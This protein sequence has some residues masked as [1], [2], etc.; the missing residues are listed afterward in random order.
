[1]QTV[2]QLL[3]SGSLLPLPSPGLEPQAGA[4]ALLYSG[5]DTGG[6]LTK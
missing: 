5:H 6:N 1:M 4:F 3:D 2:L